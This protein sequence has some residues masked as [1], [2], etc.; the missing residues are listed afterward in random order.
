MLTLRYIVPT[1]SWFIHML[2]AETKYLPLI[3]CF[4]IGGSS[5][6]NGPCSLMK[7]NKTYNG[8]HH[9]HNINY[10]KYKWWCLRPPLCTLVR[11]SWVFQLSEHEGWVWKVSHIKAGARRRTLEANSRHSGMCVTGLF[12]AHDDWTHK[13][14]N[15]IASA[16][17]F[18]T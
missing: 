4:H 11:L 9:V 3:I 6:R 16:N 12:L 15:I 10:A 18:A 1:G 8:H 2:N 13:I 5:K 7:Q 17:I 14:Y